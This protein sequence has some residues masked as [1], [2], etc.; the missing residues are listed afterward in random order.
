MVWRY[1]TILF[2][3]SVSAALVM[4]AVY[5]ALRAFRRQGRS[6]VV[7]LGVVAGVAVA[8]DYSNALLMAGV[9]LA[10]VVGRS[11]RG[12]AAIGR[13]LLA[14]VAGAAVPVL[15]LAAY[16]W[17]A[18][19]SPLHT[20][21]RY[22]Q[23]ARYAFS[24][25]VFEAY[26]APITNIGPL[27]FQ[28]RWGVDAWCPLLLLAPVGLWFAAKRSRPAAL[29]L[30]LASAPLFILIAKFLTPEGGAT[31]DARYVTP[32]LAPLVVSLAVPLTD[33]ASAGWRRAAWVASG[34][35]AVASVL[36]QATRLLLMPAHRERMIGGPAIARSTFVDLGVAVRAALRDAFPSIRFAP[37]AL[38]VGVVVAGVVW[39]ATRR[40]AL[41]HDTGR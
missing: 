18:F 8:V 10:L 2:A 28:L 41:R 34:L 3:H 31:H 35:L 38:A 30:I 24:R 40:A 39:E 13:D 36:L 22:K 25:D 4:A 26:S 17:G 19:G 32:A 1:A 9:L 21:Y 5:L 29:L 20:S 11:R 23:L 33:I 6:D 16:Q 27:L 14:V 12:V 15:L 37:I 7:W